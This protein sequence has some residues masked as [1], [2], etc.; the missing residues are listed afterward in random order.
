MANVEENQDL[1]LGEEKSASKKFIIIGAIVAVLLIGGGVAAYFLLSGDE[2]PESE[3]V[4]VEETAVEEEKGPAQYHQMEPPF[5]INLSGRPRL[6]QIGLSVRVHS[7]EMVE[8]L[9]HNDPMI[10]HHLLNLIQASDAKA[11]KE[12]A[13]KEALQQ[14]LRDELNRIAEE[15]SGPGEVDAVFFTSFVMQ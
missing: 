11:L 5:T 13:G 15:L 3:E 2:E 12:R 14:Q 1:D 7:A 10:R 8:F 6:M 9:K 4:S